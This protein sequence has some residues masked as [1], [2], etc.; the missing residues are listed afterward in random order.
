MVAAGFGLL[1]LRTSGSWRT[2]Y[3]NLCGAS[4]LYVAGMFAANYGHV[5]PHVSGLMRLPMLASFVWLGTT[6][7]IAHGLTFEPEPHPDAAATRHAVAGPRGNVGCAG[8]AGAGR[9]ESSSSAPPRPSE[10]IPAVRH[11]SRD[12]RRR[13][14]GFLPP[15]PRI[16]G[17]HRPGARTVGFAGK[18]RNACKHISCSPKNWRPS[19]SSPPAPRTKSIIHSPQFSAMP[20]C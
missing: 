6:G 20:I 13:R 5:S 11:A 4:T 15:A 1:F 3:G 12:F 8:S 7:I 10:T 18:R 16:P 2:V 19:E 9:L 17:T 14:L